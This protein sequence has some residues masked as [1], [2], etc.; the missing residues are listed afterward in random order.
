MRI[1]LLCNYTRNYGVLGAI[2]VPTY[3]AYCRRHGYEMLLTR[4]DCPEGRHVFWGKWYALRQFWQDY[5]AFLAIDVDAKITNPEL[6]VERLLYRDFV[7]GQDHGGINAGVETIIRS[8]W[9]TAF[10][11][12]LWTGGKHYSGWVNED[13][14]ALAHL[15]PCEPQEKWQVVPEREIGASAAVWQPG[16]WILHAAGGTKQDKIVALIGKGGG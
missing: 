3:S 8:P 9:S 7:V 10:L 6:K 1:A 14:T 2:T 5:D 16:D 12:R 15:L 11:E 4:H 13:Q